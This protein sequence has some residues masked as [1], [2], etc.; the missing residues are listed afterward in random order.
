[1]KLENEHPHG[2]KP[3]PFKT[4]IGTTE[5]LAEKVPRGSKTGAANTAGLNSLRKNSSNEAISQH[6]TQQGLKPGLI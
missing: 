5:R 6:S 3:R 2:L 1:V 4:L